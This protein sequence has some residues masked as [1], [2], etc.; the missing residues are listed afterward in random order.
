MSATQPVRTALCLCG[1]GI[2]GAMYEVGAL[3]AL[4]DF[5]R[6][7]ADARTF[8]VNEFDLYVGTSAGAF[9]ATTLSSGIPVRRLFRAVLDDDPNFFPVRRTDIYRFDARQGLGIMRDLLGIVASGVSRG[10]RRD[11]NLAELLSDLT[12]AL[13]AGIF[14]L[15]HYEKFIDNFLSHHH[16]ATRFSDVKKELYV[17]ANDLDTGHRVIFGQGAFAKMSIARA[18]CA[19]SAIP[20]FFEPVRYLGRD[21]IDGAVGKVRTR[22]SRSHAARI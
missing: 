13:P 7:A 18:I 17:T 16:L 6:P 5:F 11:V 9:L 20:L 4:D 2:T 19:S 10:F 3:T 8:N 12:D 15:K 21:Y 22:I 14:S 1:G